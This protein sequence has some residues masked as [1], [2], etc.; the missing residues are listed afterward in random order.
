MKGRAI[1][2]RGRGSLLLDT[3][4]LDYDMTLALAPALF[5]RLTRPELR[6]AF[7]RRP[8]GFAEVDFRLTGTTLQPR[9]DL[10]A[11]VAKAAAGQAVTDTL[12]RWLGFKKKP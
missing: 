8:D 1:D 6:S 10:A 5:A 7:R 2:L 3:G 4:A 9:T 11:R 12:S